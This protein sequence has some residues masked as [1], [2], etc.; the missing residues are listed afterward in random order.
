MATFPSK[1]WCEEAVRLVN[2]DPERSLAARGWRGD[3]GVIVDAEP[4]R[5]SRPFVVHVVTRD[6]LIETPRLLEEPDDLD[7]LEPAYLARAPYSVWKQLL[8]GSLDPVEAVLRRRIAVKGDLQQLIERLRFKGLADRVLAGL[9][10]EYL[11]DG[12]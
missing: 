8:Q 1:E 12:A 7:E 5:L 9:K 10:T 2:E 11:D 6:C 3:I 4:G